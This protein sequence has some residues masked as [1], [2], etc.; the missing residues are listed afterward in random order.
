MRGLFSGRHGVTGQHRKKPR[1]AGPCF[2][3]CFAASQAERRFLQPRT[4]NP[5]ASARPNMAWVLG[6]GTAPARIWP[7]SFS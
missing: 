2:E 1:I 6:S 7:P 3:P 5:A 4:A